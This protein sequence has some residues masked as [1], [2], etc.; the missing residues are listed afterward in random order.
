MTETPAQKQFRE[1]FA[2]AEPALYGF[3][4]SLLPNRDDADDVVQ[5]ALLLLWEHFEE[6]D[7]Q[8]PFLPWACTFVYRQVLKYRRTARMRG[9]VFSETTVDSLVAEHPQQSSW[10]EVHR[11]AV[12]HCVQ[13]LGE[14]DRQ[15]VYLRYVEDDKLT[16]H[17]AR[18]GR[19]VNALYKKLHRVRGKLARCV[20]K[21]LSREGVE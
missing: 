14:E 3:V 15:L 10:H 2:E 17:A 20:S 5:E 7:S 13:A 1:L 12:V 16:D 9:R 19:S 11:Q 21:F 8:R 4:Y 6:Y 18:L